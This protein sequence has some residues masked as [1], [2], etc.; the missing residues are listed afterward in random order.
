MRISW[1]ETRQRA[2]AFVREWQGETSERAEAKT[3]WDEFFSVFGIRRR[4]LARFEAM[5]K[6]L[7]NRSGFIDLFWPG[8]MIVEHKSAGADLDS[9]F[10]Q[11][12][13]YFEGLDEKELPQYVLVSDFRRFRL[14]DLEDA[15]DPFEF[16][17]R[18]LPKHVSRFAFM[19]GHAP[20][21]YAAEAPVNVKAAERMAALH[22]ALLKTG[23]SGH[24]LEVFLVRI[25]F[26]LFADDTGIFDKDSFRW[27]VEEKTRSDGSDTGAALNMLFQ[28]LDTPPERRLSTL[29]EDLVAFPYVNGKLFTERLDAPAFDASTREMLL[30]CCAFAWGAVSPAVFGSMF[31][32]VLDKQ[33]RRDLG[34]HYTSET[35][36]LKALKPLFLDDL[37]QAF[38]R[39][40][41]NRMGLE[42]LLARIATIRVVD[43]ACGCGNFLVIAYREL[44]LLELRIHQRLHEITTQQRQQWLGV[45]FTQGINVDAMWGVELEEFPVR[46]AETALWLVDHQVNEQAAV[47]FDGY[48]TRLP[49]TTAP[50]IRM[51]N[52]LRED[53]TSFFP[54]SNELYIVGN[55][56]F[57][58]KKRRNEQ[59]RQ[60]MALVGENIPKFGELDYVACWYVKA[61][62]FLRQRPHSK[63]AFVSTNSITQGE[64]VGILWPTL[65]EKGVRIEFGHRTF[66]WTNEARGKAQVHV[67][68]IGLAHGEG[69]PSLLVDYRTPSSEAVEIQPQQINPYLVDAPTVILR[70]KRSPRASDVPR[71]RFGSMP[72]DGGHLLLTEEEHAH[73][74]EEEPGAAP[75]LRPLASSK[76]YLAAQPRFCIWLEDVAPS[77]WSSVK[78][79]RDRVEKVRAYRMRSTRPATKRLASV[80]YLFAE[81]R[82]PDQPYIL[83]PRHSSEN[84]K[85]IPMSIVQPTVVASDSCAAVLSS[86]PFIF[87]VLMSE[88]HMAWVR[89]VCGRIK[90]DFRYSNEIVYNNFPWPEAVASSRRDAVADAAANVLTVRKVHSAAAPDELYDPLTMPVDLVR[91]HTK[92]DRAVDSY[93]GGR[94]LDSDLQRLRLLFALI[95]STR[96]GKAA[97]PKSTE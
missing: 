65:L 16:P 80:P 92:L 11:A 17:I 86:D 39:D 13:N 9:A 38:E 46:I 89:Q 63:C 64:Q 45:D 76:E 91:A 96:A 88:M 58:G 61:A 66:R 60:D 93:Y 1:N 97:T 57:I 6:T 23:Y 78:A 56:P 72:N 54:A 8:M 18:D 84:R 95:T 20:K 87:G 51:G 4:R 74:L 33:T 30:R 73:L 62:E 90:N 7:G 50:N 25:M 52:A 10:L 2:Q 48:Y 70:S 44:R 37:E 47:A 26:C 42:R 19:L 53:W 5:V 82:Q 68:I 27:F 71:I 85:Y 14:Y 29:D 94:G 43:P 22:D 35:N 34:A 83:I 32:G 59:Q 24:P 31:Q 28:V 40:R 75:F 49:L 69:K 77:A 79:I 55:P 21:I 12:T 67:V 3:F 36:I 41:H 15:S 81:R